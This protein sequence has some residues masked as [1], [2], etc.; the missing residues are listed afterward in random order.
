[1]STTDPNLFYFNKKTEYANKTRMAMLTKCDNG[2]IRIVIAYPEDRC[3]GREVIRVRDPNE[4]RKNDKR[5][6][7][8]VGSVSAENAKEAFESSHLEF[9]NILKNVKYTHE[10]EVNE[11]EKVRE[12][13]DKRRGQGKRSR[14][15]S[16]D[17]LKG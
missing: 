14:N 5:K 6:F 10:E 15:M 16:C 13:E 11:E 4:P 3:C 17:E 9:L 1:L 2:L 12:V 8:L 7:H